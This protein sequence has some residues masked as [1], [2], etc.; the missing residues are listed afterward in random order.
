MARKTNI[1]IGLSGPVMQ[2]IEE[3]QKKL[4]KDVLLGDQL[5]RSVVIEILIQGGLKKM[6]IG[7]TKN[8]K[9]K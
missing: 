4:A 6:G 5:S 8:A 2:G 3:A 7:V 9:T 1:T